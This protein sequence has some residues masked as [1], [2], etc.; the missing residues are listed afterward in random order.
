M[1][2]RRRPNP[3]SEKRNN[4]AASRR[5]RRILHGET[6][7]TRAPRPPTVYTSVHAELFVGDLHEQAKTK[8]SVYRRI[9]R[10]DMLWGWWLDELARELQQ[11]HDD[12]IAGRC[13]KLVLMAPPQHGKTLAVQDFIAWFAGKH[14]DMKIIYASYSDELGMAANKN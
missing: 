11:F 6:A 1:V 10:P 2:I 13:P 12:L 5:P 9:I 7:P 8:F 4:S 3:E 14:P